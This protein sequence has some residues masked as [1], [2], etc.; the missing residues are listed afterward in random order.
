MGYEVLKLNLEKVPWEKWYQANLL[1]VDEITE[2]SHID[3]SYADDD[4]YGLYKGDDDA[5]FLH[6]YDTYRQIK[7]WKEKRTRTSI[8]N[9]RIKRYQNE[10]INDMKNY[11]QACAGL[12]VNNPSRARQ[13]LL[14]AGTSC[15]NIELVE[16]IQKQWEAYWDGKNYDYLEIALDFSDIYVALGDKVLYEE[17]D[18]QLAIMLYQLALLRW[19]DD[20]KKHNLL[21]SK[22]ITIYRKI[23]DKKYFYASLKNKT[24]LVSD[25]AKPFTAFFKCYRDLET[26]MQEL[27]TLSETFAET[28]KKARNYYIETK[29]KI[30]KEEKSTVREEFRICYM[31]ALEIYQNAFLLSTYVLA[32]ED[33]SIQ[34][35][36]GKYVIKGLLGVNN[37]YVKSVRKI[38]LLTDGKEKDAYKTI[39]AL[40]QGISCI[41]R[42]SNILVEKE[43]MQD[44]AYYTSLETLRYMLPERAKENAGKLS[45]M[46]VAYMNDPN[47][48][49]V[50]WN[51]LD[52]QK[53]DLQKTQRKEVSYP[54]VFLKC[55]T[56]LIDD[57]PMWEMYGDGAKGCCVVF[58][59]EMYEH[60][61]SSLCFY[62]IC[63]LKKNGNKYELD[64]Q[65]NPNISQGELLEELLL[66]LEGISKKLAGNMSALTCFRNLTER[67]AFLFKNADYKHEQE[68]RIM[69]Q[70][71]EVSDSFKHVEKEYPMLYIS[72]NEYFQIKEIILGPKVE[73]ISAKIPYIQE[74]VER[75]CRKNGFYIPNITISEIEYR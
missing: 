75:M 5:A 39:L 23:R 64:L 36:L 48:G 9:R 59:N 34:S 24:E 25:C 49:K 54:Y 18:L 65:D 50:L 16:L 60:E 3:D 19:K 1:V 41:D 44:I 68:I 11:L 22:E 70:Y 12:Q 26:N 53:H 66:Q 15:C 52:K 7:F 2:Y 30:S 10:L 63:Y 58:D 33:E 17:H 57:L 74:E 67:I 43:I 46:H 42:I 31:M 14:I 40:L 29:R 37:E 8:K 55:F 61:R 27:L 13:L 32:E 72:P 62:R 56:S 21:L 45:V 28:Y 69:F 71:S 73:N 4:N 20:E 47:E 6:A 35:E 51:Y 38:M